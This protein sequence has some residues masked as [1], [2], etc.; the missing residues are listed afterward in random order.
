[1]YTGLTSMP[2]G[3]TQ[4]NC[5][6][7]YP[8]ASAAAPTCSVTTASVTGSPARSPC[9]GTSAKLPIPL[10]V[11]VVAVISG[12]QSS[13]QVRQHFDGVDLGG[14][15]AIRLQNCLGHRL[16]RSDQQN[17]CHPRPAGGI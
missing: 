9:S 12:P 5:S 4:S 16:Y 14:Q 15:I 3:V 17:V 10:P 7:V 2:S 1:M 8:C 11:P 6:G 13:E